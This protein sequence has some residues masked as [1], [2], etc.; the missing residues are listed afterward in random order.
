MTML[1]T[2]KE[3]RTVEAPD[4]GIFRHVFNCTPEYES[5]QDM[6]MEATIMGLEITALCGHKMIPTRDH[7]KYPTC[8]PCLDEVERITAEVYG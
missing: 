7:S 6:L 5:T 3:T 4:S 2:I 8:Q 1:D